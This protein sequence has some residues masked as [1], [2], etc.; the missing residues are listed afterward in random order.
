V[1][2]SRRGQAGS[3]ARSSSTPGG[4]VAIPIAIPP[5]RYF[6]LSDNCARQTF[7]VP[8]PALRAWVIRS[9]RDRIARD[10][11]GCRRE[12]LDAASASQSAADW[13]PRRGIDPRALAHG[14]TDG[15][16]GGRVSRGHQGAAGARRCA[17]SRTREGPPRPR[18]PNRP[19]SRLHTRR[20][21]G[22]RHDQHVRVVFTQRQSSRDR[23]LGRS[24]KSSSASS[25]LQS[26]RPTSSAS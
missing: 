7:A 22:R 24:W 8:G 11:P 15:L 5:G 18:R 10:R 23:Q 14:P 6:M 3:P 13:R 26:I 21:S 12:G 4:Q 9:S 1:R 20:E 16:A 2:R 25:H 19:R 17:P